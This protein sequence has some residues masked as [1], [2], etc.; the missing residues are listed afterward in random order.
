LRIEGSVRGDVTVSGETEIATS[1]S[2]EGKVT[3]ASLEVA[4]TLVGDVAARGPVAIRSSAV[5]RGD[6]S[7][8]EISIEPGARVAVRLATDFELDLGL[9]DAGAAK[10]R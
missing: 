2:V 4:G 9:D 10:R 7:G 1:G 3:A 8:S 5:V 6:L